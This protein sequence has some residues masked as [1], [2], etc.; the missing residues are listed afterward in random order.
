[1]GNRFKIVKYNILILCLI[2]V[3][4]LASCQRQGFYDDSSSLD[5]L[6]RGS[7]ECADAGSERL[8][9]VKKNLPSGF[10][11]G[12]SPEEQE[13][14]YHRLATLPDLHVGYLVKNFQKGIFKGISTQIYWQNGVAGLTTLQRGRTRSGVNGLVATKVTTA[15][16]SANFALQHEIGHAVEIVV[17]D[18]A[19]RGSVNYQYGLNQLISELRGVKDADV[20]SYATSGSSEAWAEA[21]ANYYCSED[22]HRFIKDNLPKSYQFL[23][24]VLEPPSWE[25]E[26]KTQGDSFG[27]EASQPSAAAP[28]SSATEGAA[29]NV[30]LTDAIMIAVEEPNPAANE[31]FV[32]FAT[33]PT[34]TK[35]K[36]CVEDRESCEAMAVLQDQNFNGMLF[37]RDGRNFYPK[38]RVDSRII[39]KAW[40]LLGYGNDNRLID[41]RR[42]KIIGY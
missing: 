1:M 30:E 8:A 7:Y 12:F 29:M 36:I 6:T 17:Q 33:I 19:V 10:V 24:S 42:I 25:K 16:G 15:A 23:N 22:S 21:Y 27:I 40:T 37:S 39:G 11:R 35:V 20:R 5:Y 18:K 14:I 4:W 2:M 3:G 31:F 28:R 26:G 41:S 38:F 34:I 13:D 9:F 32:T